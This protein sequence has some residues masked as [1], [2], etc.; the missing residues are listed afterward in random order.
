CKDQNTNNPPEGQD[1]NPEYDS[2]QKLVD[3]AGNFVSRIADEVGNLIL[4]LVGFND[5][6]KC[7]TEGDIVACISTALQAVPWGK[8][9]KAAKVM[10]KAIGVGR[11]LIEAYEKVKAAKA[12]LS[13]IP[14]YI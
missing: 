10:I 3:E 7:V 5:A 6:K 14:R 12:A 11:R 4:D 8:L 13:K 9:F 2:A 1:S